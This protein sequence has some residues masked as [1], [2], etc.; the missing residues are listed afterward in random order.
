MF[1]RPGTPITIPTV[2]RE[3]GHKLYS[4]YR[5]DRRAFAVYCIVCQ[6]IYTHVSDTAMHISGAVWALIIGMQPL[7]R[8][9][10]DLSVIPNQN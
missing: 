2:C 3:C 6:I 9:A 5:H 4:E 10:R 1:G 7:S 8:F